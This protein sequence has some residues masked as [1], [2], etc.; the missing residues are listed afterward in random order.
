MI[1]LETYPA[2]LIQRTEFLSLLVLLGVIISPLAERGPFARAM[3]AGRCIPENL[4][5]KQCPAPFR[6][7]AIR[8]PGPGY[9]VDNPC[10]A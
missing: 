2:L 5:S 6:G 4:D 3:R 10:C 8:K 9:D 1:Q 7:A